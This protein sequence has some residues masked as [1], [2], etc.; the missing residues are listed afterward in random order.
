MARHPT[1]TGRAVT[2]AD[3][4]VIVSKTDL[5][6]KITYVNDV[7]VTVSGY[8]PAE[9]IGAPHSLIRHPD[10]PRCVF[11]VLWQTI[12]RGREIFAY[13]LNLAKD[14]SHYWVLAHVTPS[15]DTRGRHV[16]YHSHRRAPW[17][18]AL[19]RVQPLY[20]ELLGVE[21]AHRDRARGL[22]ASVGVV[23]RMLQER[24]MEW[25][26]LVFSLSKETQVDAAVA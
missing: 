10:M 24:G 11:E 16:G 26:E 8:A 18:D 12:T 23:E 25:N 2:F 3:D 5:Q 1:P 22:A 15:Y 17:A 9:L 19:A 21:R 4:D 13:V 7:F 14:G 6:G 20:A